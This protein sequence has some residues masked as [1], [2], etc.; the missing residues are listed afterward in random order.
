MNNLSF[1]LYLSEVLPNVGVVATI[2][3]VISA[4]ASIIF[5]LFKTLI[6]LDSP[7]NDASA[8]RY[9]TYYS[10]TLK[11]FAITAII[12]C[13]LVVFI[14]SKEAV[15]LIAASEAGEMVVT[16]ETGK[17]LLSDISEVLDAQL[18]SLKPVV[19]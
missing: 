14:P 6:T 8:L 10:K 3:L 13:V 7:R 18:Q 16:S 4:T 12:A 1:I 5:F 19:K 11:V 2:V 15:Y 17:E 9:I